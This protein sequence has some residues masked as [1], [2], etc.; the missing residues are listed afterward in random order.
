MVPVVQTAENCGLSAV[1]IHL[2]RRFP[3][4]LQRLIPMVFA[5]TAFPQLRMDTV[6]DALLCRS[7]RFPSWYRGRFPW[8]RLFVGPQSFPSCFAR[9][10]MSLFAGRAGRSHPV[11]AQRRLPTVETVV[12]PKRFPSSLTRWPISLLC[13]SCRF[14][15][16]AVEKTFVLPQLQLAE[17]IVA[18][19]L[20]WCRGGFPWSR[21]V[22]GPWYFPSC[23]SLTR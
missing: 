1:A 6:V 22:C 9:R 18:S 2:G 11:D 14:S 23:S 19:S 17:K 7:C 16:A 4:A 8:S 5:T 12:G 10:P 21:L 20:S 13:W 3:V 15:G